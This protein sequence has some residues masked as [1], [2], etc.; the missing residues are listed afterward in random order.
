MRFQFFPSVAGCWRWRLM[1]YDDT[2]AISGKDFS[3]EAD[4]VASILKM[5]TTIS[6][7]HVPIEN[8]SGLFR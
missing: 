6:K 1:L 5:Q 2:L 7:E 8:I 4:C 3:S